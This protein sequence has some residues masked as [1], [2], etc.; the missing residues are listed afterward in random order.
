M[1]ARSTA[2]LLRELVAIE[3]PSGSEGAIADF[4]CALC[5]E[6]KLDVERLG[7]TLIVAVER[8]R[9][10]RLCVASHLDTVPI[11]ADWTRAPIGGDWDGERLYGRGANDAKASVAAILSAARDLARR[12]AAFAGTLL[13]ALTECEE[14]SNAGM[15]KVIERAGLPDGAITGE[16]TGLEV[17]RAQSGLAVL[18]ATWRGRSCHAAHVARVA[19]ASA[20]ASACADLARFGAWRALEGVHELVGPSTVA[21][22][23]LRA[24]ERHNVVPDRAEAVFDA[25]LSPLHS[26]EDARALLARELP[27]AEVAV[28]SARLSPFETA[29]EHPLVRA[30]LDAARKPRAIGSSTLSD[31]ALLQGVPAVKCG[32]GETSRSHTPDEFVLRGE[33]EEGVAFYAR[34][35][36]LALASL[37][38]RTAAAGA[39]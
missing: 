38:P 7:E 1:S 8:G 14:T 36:P 5:S 35:V 16:P 20:L 17:V 22:T 9:G 12:P 32:P 19:H 3:S 24:G 33:L 29:E 31:M 18:T 30:V 15:A 21:A 39:R 4:V 10:P 34:A 13:V 37:A 23:L 25:R 11:G 6:W 27:G 26:A 2:E 28:K